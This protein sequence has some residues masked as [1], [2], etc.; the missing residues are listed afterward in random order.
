MPRSRPRISDVSHTPTPSS[1]GVPDPGN[2]PIPPFFNTTFSTHRV[3]PLY[4]G[5]QDLDAARLAQLAHRL[6]DTLVGDVVRGIQIGLESTDTPVGQVGALRTVKIR[7]FKATDILGEDVSSE[8]GTEGLEKGLWIDI[9]HEN[10]S[11]VAL[12]LPST[13]S[14]T[15]PTASSW[16]AR[17][18]RGKDADES[19]RAFLHLP[20]LLLRMPL[21]LK[22]V[23]GDWLSATFDC[24]VSKLALGT[25]TLLNVLEGWLR[26]CG[27]SAKGPDCVITLTFN[28]PLAEQAVSDDENAAEG[29]QP[30]GL[31]SMDMTISPQDL[32]RFARA[33][34]FIRKEPPKKS[35]WDDDPRERRRLAGGNTDDGWAWRLDQDAT[36]QPFTDA[37]A[38]YLDRHLALNLFHPSVRVSQISCSGFVLAQSRLKIVRHGEVS[39]DLSKAAWMFVKLLGDRLRGD[40]LPTIF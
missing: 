25:K 33:G 21:A 19:N 20:L 14:P 18:G 31:R 5:K 39:S 6:R 15:V 4:L 35:A 12:L 3:S 9:R 27:I 30:P 38:L 26:T 32:R 22:Q 40:E 8:P 36:K 17:A 37:F 28:V 24:R 23:M 29:A 1:P 13:A 11:Y 7:W 34:E 2:E 16:T 10:A